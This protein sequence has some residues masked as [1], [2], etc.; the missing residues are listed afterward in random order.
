MRTHPQHRHLLELSLAPSLARRRVPCAWSTPG[1]KSYGAVR[2]QFTAMEGERA[3]DML[4]DRLTPLGNFGKFPNTRT[5]GAQPVTNVGTLHNN[6]AEIGAAGVGHWG[7]SHFGNPGPR[8]HRV[9]VFSAILE[10]TPSQ[11]IASVPEIRKMRN[12]PSFRRRIKRQP[13]TDNDQRPT[14]DDGE[15]R[16]TTTADDRRRP[17]TTAD[18]RR[19]LRRPPMT[20]NGCRRP[21]TDSRRPTTEKG[22]RKSPKRLLCYTCYEY[23]F[24]IPTK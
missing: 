3:A 20:D 21:T 5:P 14:S 12:W 11:E 23:A 4:E 1:L 9:F 7:E 13:T 2:A 6:E 15:R 10:S 18:D 16:L 17:P 8:R 19:K 22:S 24:W